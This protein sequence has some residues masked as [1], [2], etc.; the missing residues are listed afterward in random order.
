[1]FIGQTLRGAL[2]SSWVLRLRPFCL[3]CRCFHLAASPWACM[4][5]W[6]ITTTFCCCCWCCWCICTCCTRWAFCLLCFRSLFQTCSQNSSMVFRVGWFTRDR[7]SLY[8]SFWFGV[9]RGEERPWVEAPAVASSS[10]CSRSSRRSVSMTSK[11]TFR[12]VCMKPCSTA[13]HR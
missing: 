1:M 5:V 4:W 12:S 7:K 10:R 9:S 2:S 3:S 11:V 6:G 8:H 13:W